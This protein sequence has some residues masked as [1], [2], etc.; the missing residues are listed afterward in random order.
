[1]AHIPDPRLLS[2]TGPQ[3]ELTCLYGEA[4]GEP[5]EGQAAVLWVIKNRVRSGNWGATSKDVILGWAQFSCLWP[6]LGGKNYLRVMEF[7]DKLIAGSPLDPVATQIAY[8][9]DGV[10]SGALLDNTH[11]ACHYYAAGTPIPF[12]VTKDATF[13]GQKGRHLFYAGVR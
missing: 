9:R 2:L 5:M 8:L 4:S 6:T 7:V 3:L 12:W 13:V 10:S 1:M 11:G